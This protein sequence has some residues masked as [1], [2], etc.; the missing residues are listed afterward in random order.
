MKPAK[1]S[2][3][4][5]KMVQERLQRCAETA[6]LARATIEASKKVTI[7]SRELIESIQKHR[8]KPRE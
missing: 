8:R 4:F 2:P 5:E 7:E 1:A 6:Q 3:T